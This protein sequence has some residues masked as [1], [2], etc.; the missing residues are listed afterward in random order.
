MCRSVKSRRGWEG[1]GIGGRGDCEQDGNDNGGLF[2][3]KERERERERRKKIL[4]GGNFTEHLII[5]HDLALADEPTDL[6]PRQLLA[7]LRLVHGVLLVVLPFY[8]RM[9]DR[10]AIAPPRPPHNLRFRPVFGLQ[11]LHYCPSYD[12]GGSF[13]RLDHLDLHLACPRLHALVQILRLPEAANEEDGVDAHG[14]LAL[15]YRLHLHADELDDLVDDG[16]EEAAHFLAGDLEVAAVDACVFQR[17]YGGNVDVEGFLAGVVPEGGFGRFEVL[18]C[19]LPVDEGDVVVMMAHALRE[20][21]FEF[22]VYE[23]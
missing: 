2:S 17:A 7:R 4:M 3:E 8:E 14:A 9:V 10:D 1:V 21:L 13:S 18:D 5:S 19:L 20:Q 23:C 15:R 16:V 11:T 12:G 22:A 6:V